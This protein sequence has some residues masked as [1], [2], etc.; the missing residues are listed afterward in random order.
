[1]SFVFDSKRGESN[2]SSTDRSSSSNNEFLDNVLRS[3]E[4]KPVSR[5]HL[6]SQKTVNLN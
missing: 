3:T 2:A 6:T 4:T 5:A 1:M